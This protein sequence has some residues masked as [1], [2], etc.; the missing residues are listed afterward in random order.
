MSDLR[1]WLWLSQLR[2]ISAG[3]ALELLR[4]FGS[5]KALYL[6]GGEELRRAGVR[7]GEAEALCRKEIGP[8]EE[9]EENCR[10]K[11]YRILCIRDAVYPERLRNIP[12]PPLV[13]FLRG[14]LPPVDDRLC[15]GIV[16]T[17]K[18]TDYGLSSAERIARELAERG[19][20]IVTG[21]AAGIDSAAARGAL[22]AHGTVI[23][24]LG[25]G[26]DRVFPSGNEKLQEAVGRAGTLISEYTPGTGPTRYSFPQR[27]R[28]ISGLCQGVVIVEAPEKSGALI[29][30]ARAQEQGRDIFVVPG[31]VDD[32]GFRGSNGLIR[33]GAQLVRDGDDILEEYL[34]R[35]PQAV[36]KPRPRV[37]PDSADT[38]KEAID[39]A[40]GVD[41][42]S[43]SEQLE[44]LTE[45]ELKAVGQLAQ[46]PCFG[47][48]LI[49]R[50]GIPA[51]EALAALTMLQLKGYVQEENGKYRLLVQ[52]QGEGRG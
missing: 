21:L 32:P 43:L 26:L 17:R 16:G 23:G 47:D 14:E 13:L 9:L 31:M 48:E 30:A 50:T 1:Y 7:S 40:E 35:Y 18:A 34:F 25:T 27:N 45:T 20:C 37:L 49:R 10:S 4:A 24:V 15:I 3:R 36:L 46:G 42:S 44:S 33:D 2:G 39:K 41:Y 19:C 28:I 51:S 52:Y 22:A 8:A 29:T 38:T 5:A 12:D 11:G 6:A